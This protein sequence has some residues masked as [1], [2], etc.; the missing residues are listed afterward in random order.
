MYLIRKMPPID[1]SS[2]YA[3]KKENNMDKRSHILIIP[4]LQHV[5]ELTGLLSKKYPHLMEGDEMYAAKYRDVILLTLEKQ[6]CKQEN[7]II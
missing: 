6:L 1:V 4:V 7:V 5:F 3:R 2:K